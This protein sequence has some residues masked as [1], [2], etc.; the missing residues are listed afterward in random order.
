MKNKFGKETETYLN[1]AT[2]INTKIPTYQ[3]F[4]EEIIELNILNGNPKWNKQYYD[5]LPEFKKKAM[6][7][8][9]DFL[10]DIDLIHQN[11]KSPYLS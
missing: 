5:N 6:G 11:L 9:N 8:L 1:N 2:G 7:R 10:R 3:E 4:A